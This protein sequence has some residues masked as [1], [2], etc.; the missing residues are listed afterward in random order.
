VPGDPVGLGDDFSDQFLSS[1]VESGHA[2]IFYQESQP[3]G[4]AD[5]IP[6]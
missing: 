1:C 4:G 2:Q 6:R 3:I 5:E